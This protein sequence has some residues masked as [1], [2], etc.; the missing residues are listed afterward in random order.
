MLG[1]VV[2]GKTP[3]SLPGPRGYNSVNYHLIYYGKRG[4]LWHGE[5][6]RSTEC[7]LVR[8]C[9]DWKCDIFICWLWNLSELFHWIIIAASG[10][11]SKG[12]KERALALSRLEATRPRGDSV[13][14]NTDSPDPTPPQVTSSSQRPSIFV[15]KFARTLKMIFLSP[16]APKVRDGR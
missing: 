13:T 9:Y 8:Y 5:C 10:E 16:A 1:W 2:L 7:L 14:C 3:R 4:N 6:M 15:P 11:E 12:F